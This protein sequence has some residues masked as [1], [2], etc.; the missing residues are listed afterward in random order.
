MYRAFLL[1]GGA[2]PIL[3]PMPRDPKSK[4]D[5]EEKLDE[6][7]NETFPASDP[8]SVG[9]NDHPGKPRKPPPDKADKTE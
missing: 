8:V 6:A 1:L 7:L 4:A 5:I 2:P 3:C 9:R